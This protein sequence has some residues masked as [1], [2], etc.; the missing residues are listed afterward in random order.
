MWWKIVWAV[1]VPGTAE[2]NVWTWGDVEM[3]ECSSCTARCIGGGSSLCC[4]NEFRVFIF[5][6]PL[7]QFLSFQLCRTRKLREYE[8]RSSRRRNKFDHTY[9]ALSSRRKWIWDYFIHWLN[10]CCSLVRCV[11][12]FQAWRQMLASRWRILAKYTRDSSNGSWYMCGY[13]YIYFSCF[14]FFS[15]LFSFFFYS[16]WRCFGVSSSFHGANSLCALTRLTT[17]G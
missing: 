7:L 5:L 2:P 6:L 10:V 9:Y 12:S 17:R 1:C 15:L 11:R 14:W 13:M 8:T 16:F 4:V 3:L